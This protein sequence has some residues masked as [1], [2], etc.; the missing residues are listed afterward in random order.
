MIISTNSNHGYLDS[1]INKNQGG[2]FIGRKKKDLSADKPLPKSKHLSEEERVVIQSMLDSRQSPY[3]IAKALNKSPSTITREIEKHSQVTPMK[4]D[5]IN[6][7]HCKK[8]KIGNSY[9]CKYCHKMCK[10]CTVRNCT[11][12]CSDYTRVECEY[13][14]GSPHVCNG[15]DKIH[16]CKLEHRIY[17]ALAA[18]NEYKASLVDKRIGFDLTEEQLA[19]IDEKVSP[20]VIAGHSPYA[21]VR[22]LGEFIPCSEATLYRLIGAGLL[23]CRNIDL[24]ER[25]KRKPRK[26]NKIKNKDAY[27]IITEAKKGHLWSDYLGYL[28]THDEVA[29]Q[30]DCVEGKREDNA[31]IMTLYWPKEHMQLYFIMEK[32]NAENVV[33]T[34]DKIELAIGLQLFK[35][36][37][38]IIL[39]DNGHEFTD[40]AG[41]ERSCTVEGEK[42]TKI[43]FCEPNRSDEKGNCERNHRLLRK[44]IPKG[45]SLERFMQKDMTLITNHVNSYIRKSLGGICPYDTAMETYDEDFFVLLGLELIPYN[46]VNLT[47]ELV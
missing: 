42:R 14:S 15:C 47:P 10:T 22:E 18:Q 35:E 30:L 19:M 13:I 46:L 1:Y 16:L 17:Y 3:A 25:V 45:T 23:T 43:F 34:F 20:L 33:N 9:S 21:V 36:M 39:T 7:P 5:C 27:A 38:P 31:V 44:I 8:I 32:Q 40:I 24:Q 11:K 12:M 28:K 26:H 41:M 4:N 6:Y 29:V 37:F 2:I